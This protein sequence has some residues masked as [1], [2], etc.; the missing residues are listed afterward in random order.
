MKS[1]LSVSGTFYK[2]TTAM[3]AATSAC[4]QPGAWSVPMALACFVSSS[5]VKVIHVDWTHV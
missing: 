1:L 2:T 4:S 5:H 3:C